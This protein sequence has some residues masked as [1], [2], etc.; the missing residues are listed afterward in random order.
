MKDS[1]NT[2]ERLEKK[3]ELLL[4]IRQLFA[5]L[6]VYVII[7]Q[8]SSID[9]TFNFAGQ[10]MFIIILV[11]T[12][13]LGIAGIPILYKIKKSNLKYVYHFEYVFLSLVILILLFE[14]FLVKPEHALKWHYF[15]NI[16]NSVTKFF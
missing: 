11:I 10:I 3:F 13:L 16:F 1:S 5:L 15:R 14:L 2:K 9:E 6:F 7:R 12:F 8:G 4:G